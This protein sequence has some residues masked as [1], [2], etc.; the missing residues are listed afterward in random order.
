MLSMRWNSQSS[1]GSSQM[2]GMKT[3]MY[4]MP[5]MFMLILNNFSAGLT[6]YYFLAN[7]ITLG[8]N[9]IFKQFIDEEKILQRINA[10]KNKPAKKS[11]FAQRLEALQKQ[12]QLQA[13]GKKPAPKKKSR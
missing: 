7:V 3:M 5:I 10:K 9:L 1:A 13:S 4:I 8:Q 11:R 6:Y 2:P 12:Q